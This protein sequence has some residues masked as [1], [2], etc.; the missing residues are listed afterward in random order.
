MAFQPFSLG[1][2]VTGFKTKLKR[3]T[4]RIA[5]GFSFNYSIFL[6]NQP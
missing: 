2:I 6:Q 3:K 4:E 1:A 5:F